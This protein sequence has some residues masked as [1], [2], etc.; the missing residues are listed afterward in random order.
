MKYVVMLTRGAWEDAG[1]EDARQKRYAEIGEWWGK[2]AAQ[3]QIVG[4]HQLQPPASATTLVFN[5]RGE[6]RL[7]DGPFMEAKEA[8]GGYAIV[9]A[10]NLDEA[11]AIFRSFPSPDSKAEIRPVLER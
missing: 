5:N 8:I 9:E 7:I 3:G 11:I 2:H 1:S 4:G 6:S 10:A